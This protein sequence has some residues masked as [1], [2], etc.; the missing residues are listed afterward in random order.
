MAPTFSSGAALATTLAPQ[1][2]LLFM[3]APK[4]TGSAIPWRTLSTEN[5]FIHSIGESS[6]S[7]KRPFLSMEENQPPLPFGDMH[8]SS[9]SA[10]NIFLSKS[11]TGLDSCTKNVM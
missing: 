9:L 5:T 10:S 11:V 2:F 6:I 3:V 4:N 7:S 8:I 1:V